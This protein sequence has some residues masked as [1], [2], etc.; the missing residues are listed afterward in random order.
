M[1]CH[2]EFRLQ[3]PGDKVRVVIRE[4]DDDG[5]LLAASFHGDHLPLSDAVLIKMAL[6]FPLMTLKV[7][8]G[9]HIEAVRLWLKKAPYFPHK[10]VEDVEKKRLA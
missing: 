3:P 1:T 6:K 5:L 4:E 7:M 9:I 10:S 2:Y 8:A